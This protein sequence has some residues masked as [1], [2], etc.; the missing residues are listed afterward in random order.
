MAPLLLVRYPLLELDIRGEAVGEVVVEDVRGDLS[1]L[2]LWMEVGVRGGS[3]SWI[4][5]LSEVLVLF[6]LVL[7]LLV[8]W[9]WQTVADEVVVVSMLEYVWAL[10]SSRDDEETCWRQ[11][12]SI[13]SWSR[14]TLPGKVGDAGGLCWWD[15]QQQSALWS[16]D[17]NIE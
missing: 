1:V 8:E 9:Q 16:L 10:F 4:A 6:V 12:H 13:G 5:S 11:E 2:C 14:D 17:A 7:M 15:P 3:F